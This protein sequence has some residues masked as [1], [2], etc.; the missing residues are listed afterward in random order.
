MSLSYK[1]PGHG[2]RTHLD[3][4]KTVS[5]QELYLPLAGVQPQQIPAAPDNLCHSRSKRIGWGE[6]T[7]LPALIFQMRS[8]SQVSE[9]RERI[10]KSVQ[11]CL[12]LCDP[13]DCSPQAPLSLGFS[14]REYW[15]GCHFLLQETFLTQES[16]LCLLWVCHWQAD[17]TTSPTWRLGHG[18]VF[19][20]SPMQPAEV[21]S[22]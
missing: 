10:G 5:S 2:H 3:N 22:H 18:H 1:D 13:I 20:G 4:P 7:L 8:L 14:R 16:N 15:R 9:V 11:L 17:F 21:T 19:R 12:T 6:S